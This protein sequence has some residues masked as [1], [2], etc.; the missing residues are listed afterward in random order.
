MISVIIPVYNGEKTIERSLRSVLD[1][2]LKDLEVI[3]VDD[4]STDNTVGVIG[5]VKDERVRLIRQENAG[6]GMAR[7]AGLKAA[8]GEY[9]GFVDA[10]DTVE[11]RMYERMLAAARSS[12]AQVVQCAMCDIRGDDRQIRPVIEDISVTVDDREE[13]ANRYVRRLIHTNEVCNKLIL[14]RFLDENGLLFGDTRVIF[15]EDLLLNLQMLSKLEKIYFMGDAFYNYYIS[16]NGHCLGDRCGRVE[17]VCALFEQALS[18]CDSG[19]KKEIQC[20]AVGVILEYA[21]V[22]VREDRREIRVMHRPDVARYMKTSACYRCR[23]RHTA[24]MLALL[25]A[26]DSLKAAILVRFF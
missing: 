5:K 2:T 17:K 25:A 26:P 18:D 6:Q 22:A 15:S 21:A 12:G 24:L 3:V 4:G 11:P 7:N 10:D 9:V 14:K 1:Q 20:R 23:L 13:Y 8:K 16:E 19:L